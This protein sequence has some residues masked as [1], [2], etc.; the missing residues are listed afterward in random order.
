[1]LVAFMITIKQYKLS[2]EMESAHVSCHPYAR[3]FICNVCYT[4]NHNIFYCA[5]FYIL[6][7]S[8]AILSL[9]CKISHIFASIRVNEL[10]EI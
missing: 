1:M 4:R 6:Q 8:N 10:L 9:T 2:F 3:I 5:R 7:T